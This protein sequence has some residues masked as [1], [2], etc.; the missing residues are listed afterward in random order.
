MLCFPKCTSVSEFV[1]RLLFLFLLHERHEGE[2]S[3]KWHGMESCWFPLFGVFLSQKAPA[4]DKGY[5]S[6]DVPPPHLV[7]R[8]R[9]RYSGKN[10]HS[11]WFVLLNNSKK[12]HKTPQNQNLLVVGITFSLNP[13]KRG[14]IVFLV[15]KKPSTQVRFLFLWHMVTG[16]NCRGK[17]E[18]C[19]VLLS[20][21]LSS[22][23]CFHWDV[24]TPRNVFLWLWLVHCKT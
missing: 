18:V 2:G 9:R 24:G 6:W 19:I 12:P 17:K 20:L 13:N 1:L 10:N 21:F 8:R 15:G 22:G 3:E 23:I 4:C 14:L 11:V 7:L 16:Q 5:E